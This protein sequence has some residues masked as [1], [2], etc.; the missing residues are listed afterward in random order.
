MDEGTTQSFVIKMWLEEIN[1]GTRQA[2][3]RGRITHVSSNERKF[4]KDLQEIPAF[5]RPFLKDIGE[6]F[7]ADVMR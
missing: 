7:D 4:I 6:N 1:E 5:I 3:W 2:T